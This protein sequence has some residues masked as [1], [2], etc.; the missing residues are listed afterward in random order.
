MDISVGKGFITNDHVLLNSELAA[1]V[2]CLETLNPDLMDCTSIKLTMPVAEQAEPI[3][4]PND[5][6]QVL[7]SL[8][9]SVTHHLNELSLAAIQQEVNSNV[10]SNNLIDV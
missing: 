7:V 8:Q 5:S 9:E 3:G 1:E 4:M 10:L 6:I 2:C